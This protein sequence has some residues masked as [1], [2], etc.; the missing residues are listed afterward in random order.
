MRSSTAKPLLQ[1]AN[2]KNHS[3]VPYRPWAVWLLTFFLIPIAGAAGGMLFALYRYLA[4]G[5]L[6][7][8]GKSYGPTSSTIVFADSPVW[9]TVFFIPQA[10]VAAALI[11]AALVLARLAF[12]KRPQ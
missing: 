2:P 5:Q 12:K 9:F 3:P 11:V 1:M 8:G 7:T 6:R 10:A 4:I